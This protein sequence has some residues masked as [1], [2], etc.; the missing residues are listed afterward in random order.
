MAVSSK[1][2][3]AGPLIAVA[4][5]A[6]PTWPTPAD[7]PLANAIAHGASVQAKRQALLQAGC[8]PGIGP[9]PRLM[10]ALMRVGHLPQ[11]LRLVHI[12]VDELG[13]GG[14]KP[15]VNGR[16]VPRGFARAV[17]SGQQVKDRLQWVGVQAAWTAWRRLV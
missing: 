1:I 12:G 15:G 14:Q 11:G 9:D 7:G 10:G 5:Q 8:A 2:A 6:V 13:L 17:R 4:P 16:A 3:Q